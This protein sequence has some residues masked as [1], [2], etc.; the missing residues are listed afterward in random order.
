MVILTNIAKKNTHWKRFRTYIQKAGVKITPTFMIEP[1][2]QFI[3]YN[4]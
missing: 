2:L 3:I 4:K 1:N